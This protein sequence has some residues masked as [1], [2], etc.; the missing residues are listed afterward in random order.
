MLNNY[1]VYVNMC[2]SLYNIV[3]FDVV[4]MNSIVILSRLNKCYPHTH[5]VRTTFYRSSLRYTY[6]QPNKHIIHKQTNNICN[7]IW[8]PECLFV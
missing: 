5:A 8:L 2:I 7:Y 6:E 3:W 1:I 4:Y